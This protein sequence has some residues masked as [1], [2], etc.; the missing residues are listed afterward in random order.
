VTAGMIGGMRC[1]PATEPCLCSW[2]GGRGWKLLT[3]R[4]AAASGGDADECGLLRRRRVACLDC[5]GTGSRLAGGDA[6]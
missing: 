1:A 2:C 3:L 5:G 4:R 6:P